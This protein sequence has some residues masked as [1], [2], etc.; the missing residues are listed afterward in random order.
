MTTATHGPESTSID[1]KPYGAQVPRPATSAS[2]RTQNPNG[3]NG[4]RSRIA[5]PTQKDGTRVPRV[6]KAKAVAPAKADTTTS[7]ATP[8]TML[9]VA[10]SNN[11]SMQAQEPTAEPTSEPAPQPS[12]ENGG[13]LDKI[14]DG[15]K[16]I[17]INVLT[18]EK[19]EAR[20]REAAEKAAATKKAAEE[21]HA[22]T[23]QWAAATP[24][25]K[26]HDGSGHA[27]ENTLSNAT[28]VALP[29]SSP[30]GP[31]Q[32]QPTGSS[33][34]NASS[35]AAAAAAVSKPPPI[36]IIHTASPSE[37]SIPTIMTP[38]IESNQPPSTGNSPATAADE[39]TPKVS[40]PQTPDPFIPY[41]PDGPP[42]AA[43][44]LTGPVRIL[45]P[46][47]GTP[48]PRPHSPRKQQQQQQQ[49]P[50]V[51]PFDARALALSPDKKGFHGFTAT[52]PIPFAAAA[53]MPPRP[54]TAMQDGSGS[55]DAGV[56]AEGKGRPS[57][58]ASNVERV[59]KMWEAQDT[60][61]LRHQV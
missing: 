12:S 30:P 36:P 20:Q 53:P 43:I 16:R 3:Q 8:A 11:T 1:L 21:K 49:P 13:E 61:G 10:G 31:L 34:P 15:M 5:G 42:A 55:G 44:P 38:T 58:S 7:E 28:H 59:R 6:P 19:K 47:T 35:P 29:P 45:D 41:R 25:P 48:A 51:P 32:H 24:L 39:S 50:P 9:D 2:V 60:P 17:K 54:A 37:A 33:E 57:T 4:R 26:T 27:E 52:S 46:N 18:K 23:E 14:T 56:G 40:S 22:A